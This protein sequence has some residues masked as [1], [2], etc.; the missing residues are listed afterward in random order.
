MSKIKGLGVAA[1]M[2]T[3][4]AV[5]FAE[6]RVIY[7][8]DD[9]KDLY[10]SSNL[11]EFVDLARSTAILMKKT[12]LISVE[13]DRFKVQAE[14]F[15]ESMGLCPEEPFFSQPNPGF[16]SGFLVGP[17]LFV[18]A[19]HCIRDA[20]ACQGIAF[21]FDYGYSEEGKDL[22]TISS[23]NVYSCKT[24]VTR[25]QE[26]GLGKD[27]AV[28]QLDR[29]VEGRLPLAINRGTAIGVGE[30]VTVIGHPSGLPTKITSNAV[31]RSNQP[32]LPYFV[33]NLDTYGG[34]SGSAVFNT[35]TNEVEGI[36]VRGETD[37]VSR[38]GCTVSNRCAEGACRGEDVTKTSVF[39]S[40][41]PAN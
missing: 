17:D 32:T 16:C 4:S 13:A 34:N 21:V 1:I 8:E 38:N 3:C 10:D 37:F 12:K 24:L 31:V 35:S 11:P 6:S 30:G 36:L 27:Y 14:L 26:P 39:A 23:S 19:G 5:S 18:T 29:N 9:R 28:V 22:S 20:A 2:M 40:F 41:I 15:G 7:G 25:M 33:A